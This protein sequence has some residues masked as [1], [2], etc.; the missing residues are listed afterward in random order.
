MK[1]VFKK[2]LLVIIMINLMVTYAYSNVHKNDSNESKTSINF[3][4]VKKGQ[5]LIIKRHDVN[6]F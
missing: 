4:R 1:K 2:C 3:D 6:I 5:K